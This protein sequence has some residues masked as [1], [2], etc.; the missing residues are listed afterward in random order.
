MPEIINSW[1]GNHRAR[2]CLQL[3]REREALE[4]LRSDFEAELQ[5]R[6]R[7]T[8]LVGVLASPGQQIICSLS[9]A[10]AGK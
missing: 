6:P 9:R 4:E 3:R 2:G 10:T 8:A 5:A 7:P 1:S